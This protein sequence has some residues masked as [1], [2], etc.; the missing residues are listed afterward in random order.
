MFRDVHPTRVHLI[1]GTVKLNLVGMPYSFKKLIRDRAYTGHQ[2][3]TAPELIK[4]KRVAK[5]TPAVDVW[6]MGCCFYALVTKADPFSY[7]D[8]KNDSATIKKNIM[9]SNI[10]VE[11]FLEKLDD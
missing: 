7:S 6:A 11:G 5:V 1:N 2:N 8:I 4:S 3:F 9:A 10:D